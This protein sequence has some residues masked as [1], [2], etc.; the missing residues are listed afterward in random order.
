MDCV[1]KFLF[2][3]LD[4]N[5]SHQSKLNNPKPLKMD[6]ENERVFNA[7]SICFICS[8]T[9]NVDDEKVRDHCH[10]CGNFRGAAHNSCNLSYRLNRDLN[11]I[12]H[13]SRRYDSHL[14]MQKLGPICN[15]FDLEINCIP[16]GMEDYLCFS[17]RPKRMNMFNKQSWQIRFIDSFQFLPTSL[18]TLV[19]NLTTVGEHSFQAA[20][21][22]F[23]IYADLSFILR[24]GVY[25]YEYM[26]SP[27]KI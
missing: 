24:K 2:Y 26:N 1:E 11:V 4:I 18:D 3:V 7:T 12:M 13:N 19:Q 20:M 9:L 6:Q 15:T 16:K 27:K 17:I 8:K 5:E 25:P 21:N 23:P 10:I 22:E 14:I